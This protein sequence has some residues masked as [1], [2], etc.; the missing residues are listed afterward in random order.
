MRLVNAL[1]LDQNALPGRRPVDVN[2]VVRTTAA[3]L[4]HGPSDPIRVQLGLWP[5]PLAVMAEVGDLERVLLNLV[6]NAYDAMNNGG[7][8]TI[9]TTT[10]HVGGGSSERT[11]TPYACLIIRDTG[12]G[13][14]ADVKARMFDPFF[15]TKKAGTG[16][17]LRSVAVT[18]QQLR[19][20]ISVDSEP[21]RGTAMTVLLPLAPESLILD[22]SGYDRRG[23]PRD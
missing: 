10:A 4:S 11:P 8:L 7:V 1:L 5:E 12:C 6:L 3:T 15:T 20:R 14:T 18:V 23:D 19:G 16:L 22:F 21:G 13:M 17:G 2:E 9:E